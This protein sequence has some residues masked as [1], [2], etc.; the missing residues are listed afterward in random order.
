M[1]NYQE[2]KQPVNYCKIRM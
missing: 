1:W 2:K